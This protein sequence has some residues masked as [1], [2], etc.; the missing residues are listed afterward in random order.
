MGSSLSLSDD[1]DASKIVVGSI[2][3]YINDE[4]GTPQWHPHVVIAIDEGLYYTVCGTSQQATIERKAKNLK[5]SDYSCFPALGPTLENKLSKD[6]FF[7]CT[8]YFEIHEDVL[9]D[10]YERGEGLKV[11]GCVTYSDYTQIRSAL[12]SSPTLDIGDLLVHP[13]DDF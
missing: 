2:I 9:Q 7:D 13:E 3:W 5:L 4:I 10:K 8:D 12:F 1:F 11:S 6:T